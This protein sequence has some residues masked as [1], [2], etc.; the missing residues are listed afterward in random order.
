MWHLFISC[1][2]VQYNLP[3]YLAIFVESASVLLHFVWCT[4]LNFLWQTYLLNLDRCIKSSECYMYTFVCNQWVNWLIPS[5]PMIVFQ[6][7]K[8]NRQCQFTVQYKTMQYNA[9]Q[10]NTIYSRFVIKIFKIL[11]GKFQCVVV[12]S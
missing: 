12:V 11:T 7:R 6:Q 5:Y 8:I 1:F 2:K 4:D 9:M 10:F 3:N